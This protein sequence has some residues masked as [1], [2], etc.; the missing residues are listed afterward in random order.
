[1][2]YTNLF[3]IL[4]SSVLHVV[5]HVVLKSANDRKAAAWWVLVW[6]II[7]FLPLLL[8]GL[9]VIP[10]LTWGILL[11]SGVLQTLYFL[12]IINAYQTE[13]LSVVYPLARGSAPAFLLVWSF[14][15]LGE[16]PTVGGM[17]G[18]LL[19]AVGLYAIG[20]PNLR[21][22]RDPLRALRQIGPRWALLAG[23]CISLYTVVDRVGV[24]RLDPLI[25]LYVVIWITLI[26]ITPATIRAVGWQGL[27]A[28]WQASRFNNVIAGFTTM[29]AYAVVLYAIR[30]GTPASYAGSIREVSIVLGVV[31]GVVFLKEK[32]TAMRFVGAAC[33]AAGIV[34][35]KILG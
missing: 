32:G 8:F 16:R 2:T 30:N 17:A 35:I 28:E 27:R 33:V 15:L 18:I 5:G 3:L 7:L 4:G 26:L 25:Y 10:P 24:Q 14:L 34:M 19:I 22:W 20:L 21:A 29:A 9:P 1:M 31:V 12:S 23:L 13:D 11:V 6:S